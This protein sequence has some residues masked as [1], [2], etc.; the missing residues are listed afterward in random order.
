MAINVPGLKV[1]GGCCVSCVMK[2]RDK[3]Y[4]YPKYAK[5]GHSGCNTSP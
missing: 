1:S 4:L 2:N 3:K 5:A